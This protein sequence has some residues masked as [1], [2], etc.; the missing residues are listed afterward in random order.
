MFHARLWATESPVTTKNDFAD[1]VNLTPNNT[2]V[3]T[4]PI[5]LEHHIAPS[6]P[7]TPSRIEHIEKSL[8]ENDL[9]NITKKPHSKTDILDWVKT[10]HSKQHIQSIKESAPI[11]HKVAIA[12]VNASLS[13]IDYVMN[14]DTNNAFCAT[15]PPGHHALNT[16]KEEGFCYYNHVAIAARYAQI[17][18]GLEKILIIDWDYHH[19][20]STEAVFYEDS[21]V[22]FFST[23]DRF[24]YP[25]TGDPAKKGSGNGEGYNINIHLPCGT[26]DQ[27]IVDKYNEILVPEAKRFKPDLVLISAGF[28]SRKDDLLGCFDI[29]DEGFVELTKIVMKIANESSNNRLVSILEGGYNLKGNAKAVIAHIKQLKNY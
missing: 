11:A 10:V 3:I 12:A 7:E 5:F 18:Y 25:G 27:T 2:V 26:S 22:L 15:R 6:H 4:D 19:G 13:A 21:S 16:G 23:H 17:Q 20:N 29:T 28:D 24:A 9:I 1:T 14:N 8:I